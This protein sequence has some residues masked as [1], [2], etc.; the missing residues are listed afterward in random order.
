M[1]KKIYDFHIFKENSKSVLSKKKELNSLFM[2]VLYIHCHVCTKI[3]IIKN[4]KVRNN[5]QT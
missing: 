4:I 5:R 1:Q 3:K 2:A